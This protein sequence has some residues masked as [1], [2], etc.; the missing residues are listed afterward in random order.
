[1]DHSERFQPLNNAIIEGSKELREIFFERW[2]QWYSLALSDV[3]LL[4]DGS[5][6]QFADTV[7]A[8]DYPSHV[9]SVRIAI[10]TEQLLISVTAEVN[11]DLTGYRADP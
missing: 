5:D 3:M 9:Y 6:V 2:A 8:G 10:F 11:D 4:T 7:V 1:M